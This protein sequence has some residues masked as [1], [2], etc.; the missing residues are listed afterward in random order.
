MASR[1]GVRL[2]GKTGTT[3]DFKDAWFV[4]FSPNVITAAWVGYDQPRSMGVS[5]D[6][7]RT[8]LPIWMDYMREAAPREDDR[9]FP[10]VGELEWVNIDD[11]S[12]RRVTSGG[13]SFPFIKGTA[14]ESSGVTSD[15]YTIEDVDT[16]L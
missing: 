13:R 4:G 3:N 12:G 2:G 5:S 15:Q 16:E 7:G 8:A 9:P 14:P 10:I 6:G 11:T 1:L